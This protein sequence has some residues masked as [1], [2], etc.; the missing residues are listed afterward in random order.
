MKQK[1]QM[2]ASREDKILL[3]ISQ[4]MQD[5]NQLQRELRKLNTKIAKVTKEHEGKRK[6]RIFKYFFNLIDGLWLRCEF[7]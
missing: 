4:L 7:V 2:K 1:K 5:E 6:K 3:F